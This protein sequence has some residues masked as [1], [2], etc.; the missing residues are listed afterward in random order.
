MATR[1]KAWICDSLLPGILVS[2]PGA[3][4]EVSLLRVLYV[5][6]SVR[7]G[8][9]TSRGVLPNMV[10]V[11]VCEEHSGGGVGPQGPSSHDIKY[12]YVKTNTLFFHYTGTDLNLRDL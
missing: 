9:P 8:D 4:M 6:W 11:C 7:R 5:V 2:N 3:G 1:T 10:C 12:L